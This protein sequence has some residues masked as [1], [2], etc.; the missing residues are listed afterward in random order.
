MVSSQDLGK[1]TSLERIIFQDCSQSS[2]CLLLQVWQNYITLQPV[3]NN[4]LYHA[5][6]PICISEINPDRIIQFLIL[7]DKSHMLAFWVSARNSHRDNTATNLE[8]LF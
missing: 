4:Y 2:A 7:T 5:L 3:V 1:N 8:D 6:L